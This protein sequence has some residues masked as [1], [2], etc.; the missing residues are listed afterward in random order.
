M[1][2]REPW[3]TSIP[4]RPP[5]LPPLK[6]SKS[7]IRHRSSTGAPRPMTCS[8]VSRS[9][10]TPTRSPGSCSSACSSA[11]PPQLLADAPL[12]RAE[13]HALADVG[14]DAG[15]GA[16]EPLHAVAAD[17]DQFEAGLGG[18]LLHLRVGIELREQL[19]QAASH[20]GRSRLR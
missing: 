18:E 12:F 19:G 20:V 2:R 16:H 3:S 8:T 9:A 7:S 17:V 11:E 6:R 5:A 10:T 15:P 1:N 14:V 4:R 13:T